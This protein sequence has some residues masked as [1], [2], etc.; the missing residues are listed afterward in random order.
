MV[1]QEIVSPGPKQ[2]QLISWP[3]TAARTMRLKNTSS[4]RDVTALVIRSQRP[5]ISR[6]PSS[7]SNHGKVRARNSTGPAGSS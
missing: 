3:F 5:S 2:P 7:S 6:R 1:F 4:S